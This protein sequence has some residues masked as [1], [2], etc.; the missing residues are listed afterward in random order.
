MV[1]KKN[2]AS[3]SSAPVQPPP[4]WFGPSDP[5]SQDFPEDNDLILTKKLTETLQSYDIYESKEELQRRERI[6]KR[7]EL[8]YKEWLQEMCDE[9]NVPEVVKDKVGGKI[10]PFGSY[11]LGVHGKGADID[12]LCV[13]PGFLDRKEFFTSFFEKLKAQGEVKDI[14][15]IEETYVPVIKLTYGGIEIDLVFGRL[16]QR[17]V[18]EKLNLLD[19]KYVQGI[20]KYCMRSLNGYRVTEEILQHVPNVHN[21]RIALRA[22]K[23]WAKKRNIYSNSLGF[24]GGVSW[25]I[26][27]ARICQSYPN[28]TSATLVIKFFK[29][30]SMWIWPIPIHLHRVKNL[31][32]PNI[33]NPNLNPSDRGHQMP[34]ITPAYPQQNTSVNTS[35]FTVAV[36]MEEI[37]RGHAIAQ[38]IEQNKANWSKLFQT[39]DFFEKY[40]HYI[41][42]EASYKT[43][44]QRLEWVGLV[45]SKVR[46]LVRLLERNKQISMA[47]VYTKCSDERRKLNT[48]DE[49]SRTWLVGLE[50]KEEMSMYLKDQLS[51]IFHNFTNIVH[52]L[53]EN[54]KIHQD[55]ASV[56][57][58]YVSGDDLLYTPKPKSTSESVTVP[59]SYT[60]TVI[61]DKQ[62]KKRRVESWSQTPTKK[63]KADKPPVSRNLLFQSPTP[64][65]S[66]SPFLTPK[67][68]K[69]AASPQPEMST[70]KHKAAE[71]P[72]HDK[73]LTCSDKPTA[74]VSPSPSP[75]PGVTPQDT[76]KPGAP[77][78]ETQ[79]RKPTYDSTRPAAE[80][81]N[82]PSHSN[83]LVPDV[84]RAIKLHLIRRS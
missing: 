18:P 54:S 81:P 24:L 12:A 64:S 19:D 31:L 57:A 51:C 67:A 35:R 80:L 23:L 13:G 68:T 47:H 38:E 76:R 16:A 10:L 2:V 72:T 37:N 26:L 30:Y 46:V 74:S 70:K 53:A 75:S 43:E 69:R 28:A 29:V 45:E 15:A 48:K 42:L 1:Q 63:P 83:A 61:A 44:R 36:M 34:I 41:V 6:L 82:V 77:A 79:T 20:D 59:L 25:A 11:H 33:W 3:T 39:Q 4:K 14:R 22:I 84:K 49:K 71:K 62:G 55:G 27:M 9:M 21:F 65:T 58:G 52:N 17:S 60:P 8:L 7:L 50:L 5:I 40:Q 66:A 73:K 78:L 56:S 32:D